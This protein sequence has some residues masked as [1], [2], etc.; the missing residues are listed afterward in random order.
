MNNDTLMVVLQV[1]ALVFAV[2]VHESAHGA[3]ALWCGD[4]TARDL[5]RITLNPSG[6]SCF[7]QCSP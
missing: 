7:P 1:A 4:P 5:G 2:C 6:R 3:V